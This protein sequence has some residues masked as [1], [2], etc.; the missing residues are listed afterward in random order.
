MNTPEAAA[1]ETKAPKA[2]APFRLQV[3]DV[4][5]K[6]GEE[7][8]VWFVSEQRAST[9]PLSGPLEY[10]I[11]DNGKPAF[12]A[13]GKG[14]ANVT[15]TTEIKIERSLGRDGLREFVDKQKAEAKEKTMKSKK[16]AKTGEKKEKKPST[17]GLRSGSLGSYQGFSVASVVRALAA[18]G[19]NFAEIRAFLNKEGIESSDQTIKLNIYRRDRFQEHVPAPLKEFPAKPKVETPA[20]KTSKKDAKKDAKPAK[21]EKKGKAPAKK[22]EA[23]PKGGSKSSKKSAPATAPKAGPGDKA[24]EQIEKLK[25]AAKAA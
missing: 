24:K 22:L 2:P 23:K 19:W 13:G 14:V 4:F 6:N 8:V 17:P 18:K 21:A 20:G 7:H 3:G 15:P 16:S 5:L 25:A 12:I 10:R 9:V 11:K 1:T